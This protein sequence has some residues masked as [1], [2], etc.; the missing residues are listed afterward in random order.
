[1]PHLHFGEELFLIKVFA[2]MNSPTHPD[3]HG[4][5]FAGFMVVEDRLSAKRV[6]VEQLAF[7][8]AL[9]FVAFKKHG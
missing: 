4:R 1:M 9:L 7:C 3:V 8:A 5:Y 6:D 2:L